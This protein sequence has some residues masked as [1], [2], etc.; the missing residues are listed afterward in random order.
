MTYREFGAILI[1]PRFLIIMGTIIVISTLWAKAVGFSPWM[2][3]LSLVGALLFLAICIGLANLLGRY[4][5][6]EW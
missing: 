2:M 3:P 5:D 4:I 1:N 6:G